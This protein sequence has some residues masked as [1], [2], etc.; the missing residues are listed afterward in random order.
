MVCLKYEGEHLLL[1]WLLGT[2]GFDTTCARKMSGA[3]P[4]INPLSKIENRRKRR[5]PFAGVRKILVVSES[6][7]FDWPG[8]FCRIDVPARKLF[9]VCEDVEQRR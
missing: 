1:K 8:D 4:V 5:W 9:R 6:E 3:T 7:M 2:K